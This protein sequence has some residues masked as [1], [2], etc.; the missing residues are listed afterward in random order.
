MESV[1]YVRG[2]KT[3]CLEA[4]MVDHSEW[5]S[6]NGRVQKIKHMDDAYLRNVIK[7]LE[8]KYGLEGA[9][10]MPQYRNMLA[11]VRQRKVW[12]ELTLCHHMKM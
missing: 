7:Y 8:G 12:K 1:G 10:D 3:R 11:E 9:Y 2:V 6:G 5:K 4:M